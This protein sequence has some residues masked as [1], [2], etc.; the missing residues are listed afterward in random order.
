MANKVRV[1]RQPQRT[2]IACQGTSGKRELVRLVRTA[3]GRVLVDE[4]G[5]RPGRGA[6]ICRRRACWQLALERQAIGRALKVQLS[7]QDR[8]DIADY[9]SAMPE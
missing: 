3:E 7:E 2:C 5:K 9:T 6:Y 1:R 8:Q 4:T